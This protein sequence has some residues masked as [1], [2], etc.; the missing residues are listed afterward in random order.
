MSGVALDHLVGWLEASVGDLG[1]GELFVVGF[2][3][4]DDWGVGD[5]R[6]VNPWVGDQV[7]LELGKIDVESTI[8]SQRG[9]DGGDDLTDEPVEVGVGW[10]LD[11]EVPSADV[12]DGLVVDHKG[13]VG[14]LE[15]GVRGED[16]VVWLN[17]GGGDLRSWVDGK[18]ELGFL[19]I[20]DRKP[21]HQE[22]SETR[23]GTTTKGVED[24]ETLKTGTLIGELSDPVED[25]V[26]DFFTD[27]VVT[28][29]VVVG[30]IFFTGDQ[31][32]GVEELSVGSGSD[33]VDD[34]G[35]E[36]DKDSPGD[37]LAG[38]SFGEKG[39]EGVVATTDGFVGRHLTVWLDAVLEAV[40]LP[41]SITD[42]GTGL[43]DVDRDDFTHDKRVKV[44]SLVARVCV[45]AF[46]ISL[47]LSEK[48]F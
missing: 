5:Q 26:D 27:G 32:F 22:G 10:P 4:R 21:L 34:G 24:E 31:L 40:E 25:Q 36:I 2:L 30:G 45:D 47:Q 35:F 39:V 33:L 46:E 16:R 13:T 9:G 37:V 14:V 42:L 1:D 12:V 3:G 43:T 19:A 29:S 38:T 15:G 44:F 8:E 41:A 23:T 20:V 48:I 28:T 6:K 18:L 7:G 11:V 17:D